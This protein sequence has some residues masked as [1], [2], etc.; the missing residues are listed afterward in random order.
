MAKDLASSL[1]GGGGGGGIGDWCP[2]ES[3]KLQ[4]SR[5]CSYMKQQHTKNFIKSNSLNICNDFPTTLYLHLVREKQPSCLGFKD[6]KNHFLSF[7]ILQDFWISCLELAWEN[8]FL[9]NRRRSY[10]FNFN[11][12]CVFFSFLKRT[13]GCVGRMVLLRLC[14]R[15]SKVSGWRPWGQIDIMGPSLIFSK[16]LFSWD[17]CYCSFSNYLRPE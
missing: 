10:S 8:I 6:Y 9:N 2:S 1:W 11:S 15:F 3:R 5:R 17:P 16:G 4:P 13:V 12:N 7:S 14:K